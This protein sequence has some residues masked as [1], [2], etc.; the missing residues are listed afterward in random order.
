VEQNACNRHDAQ[1]NGENYATLPCNT[2]S[3]R[4]LIQR[5]AEFLRQ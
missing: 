5:H 2:P 3:V 4:A 1:C